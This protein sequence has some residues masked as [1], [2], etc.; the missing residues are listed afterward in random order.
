MATSEPMVTRLSATSEGERVD[1]YIA[2]ELDT[3]SRT[4]VQRL[5]D[6]G[7][8]TVNG[9]VVAASARLHVGDEI[10]IT[11][12]VPQAVLLAPEAIALEILYE[13][14]DLL[15]IN[16]PAGLVV[17]PGAGHASGTLVNA[18]L[19]HCPDLPGVGGEIRPGIVHRLDKDTSGL[20]VVA[21]HDQAL[22][23]LQ[24]QFKRRTVR[25]H[26]TALVVGVIAQDHGFIEAPIARDRLHRRRMAVRGDGKPARTR[27]RVL[28]RYHDQRGRAYTLL[29]VHLLTGRTHQIRV[30][31][32]WMG[33]PLVGDAVYGRE[34]TAAGSPRQFL[35]A[36]ELEIE[37]PTTG[38]LL[39]FV[40]PLPDDLQAVL[41]GLTSD[42]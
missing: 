15:V 25:K 8:I 7:H 24:R 1:R 39:C 6:Q 27:W 4:T 34:G 18:I 26:Y 9:A 32:S 37:H 35:H 30:H 20:I 41:D 12:P 13:D 19:A 33:Y 31:L 38:E 29:D 36:R 42:G 22:H 3:L 14:G 10:E 40:A 23:A 11:V 28:G 16:K 5:I 2:S 21:K 17:H